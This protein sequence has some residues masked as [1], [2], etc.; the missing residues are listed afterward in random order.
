MGSISEKI[1]LLWP[2][3]HRVKISRSNNPYPRPFKSNVGQTWV[4]PLCISP[5]HPHAAL[6]TWR[7][8]VFQRE[9]S[10]KWTFRPISGSIGASLFVVC[11]VATEQEPKETDSR[12]ALGWYWIPWALAP[13][14]L[15]P[16]LKC[17]LPSLK[18]VGLLLDDVCLSDPFLCFPFLRDVPIHWQQNAMLPNLNHNMVPNNVSS[19]THVRFYQCKESS[20]QFTAAS[21]RGAKQ[22]QKTRPQWIQ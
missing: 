13:P 10:S 19:T 3:L 2:K 14:T 16:L 20:D 21:D 17:P 1:S 18:K 22:E 7:L 4:P 15:A 8:I 9:I 6:P 5:F 12:T 11:Y